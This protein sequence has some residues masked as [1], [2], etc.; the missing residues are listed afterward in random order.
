MEPRGYDYG[1]GSGAG[2]K[3]R[4]HHAS[5]AAAASPYA[6]PAPAPVP[7]AAAAAASQGGGWFSRVIAAG[8]SRLLPS[9]FRKPP[10]Q[11]PAPAPPPPPPPEAL[12]VPPSRDLLLEPRPEPLDAPPSP[13]PPPLE[14]DLPEGE[15]N[16]GTIVNDDIDWI[17]Y[18]YLVEWL[19][20]RT[21]GS[22]SLKP[23]D[24][25]ERKEPVSEQENGSRY[26]SLPVDFST[27]TYSVA[28]GVSSRDLFS[29]VSS[30]CPTSSSVHTFGRQVLKRKSIAVNN[31]T[32]SVG[33]V[34]R[35][36]QRYNRTSPL[37]ETRP[38]S[39]RYLGGHGSKVDEGSEQSA[40]IQKRRCLNKVGDA[41]LGSLDYRAHVN[42]GQAPPQSAEMAAKIL[43]QLDTL[44]PVQ[45][46][47]MSE[48]K[49][50]HKNAMDFSSREN[51]VS[52][53]SN[54][55]G[56]SP[57]KVKDTP[58]AVTEKIA[59]GAS[60]KS[61]NEK[62][63]TSSLGSHAPNLVLSSEIDR[64][65]MLIPSNGFTFPVPAGLGA[66]ALAPPTP[67]L[68]SPPILP[69]E[70]QQPSAV[71]S[72]N[73]S[74]ETNPR[75][76]QSVPEDGSKVHKLDNKLNA[77]DKPMP[78]KSSGQGASFTSNPVFK[79][80]NS[81]PTSLSNGAGHK[82]NSTTSDIQP[83]NGS[84]NSVSFQYTATTISTNAMKSPPKLTSNMFAGTSQS[85]AVSSL[86]SSGTGSPSAPF[87]FSP[88][89]GT[90]SSSATQDIPKAASPEAAVLFGNQNA[91][92][93]NNLSFKSSEKSNNGISQSF[94]DSQASSAPMGSAP[95]PNSIFPWATGSLSGSTS[96]AATA[97]LS[98]AFGSSS[99]SSASL[100]FGSTSTTPFSPSFGMPNTSPAASL[101]SPPPSAIFSFSS[102]TPSVPNPSPTTPFGGPTVQINGGNVAADRNGSPFP[103]AS[104]FGLPSSSPST[105]AF[106]TPASQFASN[107]PTSPGIF[108]FSQ[109]SQASSGGFSLGT[110]G[111]NDKSSRR[112]IRVKK[113]K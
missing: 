73:T 54:H 66:H 42:S 68:T 84:T 49:Q 21:I 43:K 112:I 15:E 58:A 28:S 5:R 20:S 63:T 29:P 6:R 44:V 90:A 65:K 104:P 74:I 96:V 34:R 27:K 57:S 62:T 77:D 93:G 72:A 85:V 19:W 48:P 110:G 52:A 81:K 1:R 80:V 60:N 50:K 95:N 55:L 79:V 88:L 33:P 101:F 38:G 106:S 53:Q 16:S 99:A 46:E 10:L 12:E 39:G 36:H 100:M 2:G 31:E 30:P 71:F 103:T 87:G 11:L 76:S 47:N 82:L 102:S 105:P 89:F 113:R 111:G 9:V 75:I 18:E 24:V 108:G 13:Q 22:S 94:A 37:L 40:R 7:S 61:D 67:T 25:N 14:D 32:A 4:R 78:S 3:I 23:E 41:T 92:S 17:E 35:L 56:P 26:I 70:K 107:T 45:K 86:A 83:S 59:D 51:E 69:V 109:Q 91:L 8:A 97:P 98:S 64:N